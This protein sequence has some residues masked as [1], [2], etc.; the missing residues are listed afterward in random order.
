M[1][2]FPKKE[3]QPIKTESNW[4]S[5]DQEVAELALD[6]F[7]TDK[8]FVV[9]APIAGITKED[10]DVSVSKGMLTIRGQ[11]KQDKTI[12]KKNYLYEECFWGQFMRRVVLPDDIDISVTQADLKNGLLILKIP[13]IAQS[14]DTGTPG[15]KIKVN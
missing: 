1:G 8:E 5:A 7:E 15:G 4:P 12:E 13:K 6:I 11:R 10:L 14:Q 9:I 2:I 3:N